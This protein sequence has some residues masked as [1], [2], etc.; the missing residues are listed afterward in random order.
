MILSKLKMLAA[1]VLMAATATGAGF[2][3]SRTAAAPPRPP[4]DPP[5][6]V[7]P[8]EDAKTGE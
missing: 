2:L 3:L 7:K 4:A 1:V 8:T 5:A 6:D